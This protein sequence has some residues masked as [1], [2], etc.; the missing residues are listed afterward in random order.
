MHFISQPG[1]NIPPAIC[2][3]I[4]PTTFY[5]I[6]GELSFIAAAV[7][8]DELPTSRFESFPEITLK[9]GTVRP[10]FD[11]PAMLLVFHPLAFIGVPIFVFKPTE[12]IYHIISPLAII[13]LPVLVDLPTMTVGFPIAPMPLENPAVCEQE[14]PASVL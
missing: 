14:C 13:V 11:P 10:G 9:L 4:H 12:S 1:A 2:P 3:C 7:L 6:P 5:Q 8:P